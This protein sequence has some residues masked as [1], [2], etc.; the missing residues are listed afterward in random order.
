VLTAPVSPQ[1]AP[2]A[3]WVAL[4]APLAPKAV[5]A[6]VRTVLDGVE[7]PAPAARR[8]LAMTVEACCELAR[9]VGLPVEAR[10]AAL[11]EARRS[12]EVAAQVEIV[13]ATSKPS[14]VARVLQ[15]IGLA[16]VLGALASLLRSP[17]PAPV[18]APAPR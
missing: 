15:V 2:Q 1:E 11:Q 7:H 13:R 18:R 16:T 17:E 10:V 14:I 6:A 8:T 5:S 4:V 12:F 3:R 9:E